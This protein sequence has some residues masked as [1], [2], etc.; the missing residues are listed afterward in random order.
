M[1]GA[2]L[3]TLNSTM[4]QTITNEGMMD[5]PIINRD[6]AGLLFLQP[7]VAPT[8]SGPKVTSPAVRLRG[9]M[10]DQNTYLLDGGN[11]T[12]DFDGDNGTYVGSRSARG[13]HADGK[14]GRSSRQHQQHD[15]RL[16]PF[17]RR[18]DVDEHQARHESVPRFGL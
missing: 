2:E 6:A 10:S 3:Q 12:S 8:M 1:A 14:H 9:N 7:T 4:G 5:L 13:A 15:R 18:P 11:A 16:W 17:R